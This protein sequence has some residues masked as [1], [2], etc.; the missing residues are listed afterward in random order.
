[1]NT[2]PYRNPDRVGLLQSMLEKH[3]L[4]VDGAMGTMIQDRRLEEQDFRN[5]RLADHPHSL[6]G[7][8]DLLSLTR[9]DSNP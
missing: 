2:L 7:N 6:K 8:N 9:P 3:I 5:D 4:I 1:M